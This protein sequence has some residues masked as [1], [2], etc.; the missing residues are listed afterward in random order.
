M[1]L[2]LTVLLFITATTVNASDLTFDFKS[3]GSND[4]GLQP[5]WNKLVET[6]YAR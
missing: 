5:L 1:K 4:N 2:L 6:S 3:P